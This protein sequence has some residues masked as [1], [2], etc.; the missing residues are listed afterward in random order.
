MSLTPEKT[1]LVIHHGQILPELMA[2]FSDE[3]WLIHS[4]KFKY[5]F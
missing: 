5:S 4:L 1:I 3:V 2:D